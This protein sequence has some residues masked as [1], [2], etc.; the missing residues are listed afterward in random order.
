MYGR[1]IFI[2]SKE[3]VEK[4]HGYD[5]K[6]CTKLLYVF[7]LPYLNN[8]LFKLFHLNFVYHPLS[9]LNTSIKIFP[10]HSLYKH[11]IYDLL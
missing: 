3:G 9:Y 4:W 6:F 7:K 5:P 8:E 11:C 10:M 2:G 1:H